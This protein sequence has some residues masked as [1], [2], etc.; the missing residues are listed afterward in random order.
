MAQRISRRQLARHVV[1]LLREQPAKQ[2]AII[3]QLAA[4]LVVHKMTKQVDLVLKDIADEMFVQNKHVTAEISHVHPIDEQEIRTLLGEL[5]VEKAGASS[6][7]L[8]SVLRPEL[9][10]GIVVRTPRQELDA[11]VRTKLKQIAGGIIK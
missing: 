10:G 5:L 3:Q 11:S 2:E 9:L 6:V 4:Y 8:H 7:E 1:R